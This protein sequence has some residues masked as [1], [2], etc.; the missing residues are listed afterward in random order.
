M[1]GMTLATRHLT[2]C[3]W[4]D[5]LAETYVAIELSVVVPMYNEAAN[6][7]R[8]TDELMA[9]LCAH[10]FEIILV[11]DGSTDS[12]LAEALRLR[13]VSARVHVVRHPVQCGQS[14]AVCSGV[15]AARAPWIA[16]IDGDCQNDP[17]DIP[18]LLIA[19]DAARDENVR[20]I[21]GCRVE[22][23]DSSWRRIQ[24]RVANIVRGWLLRDEAPD[25]GCGLKLFA[26]DTFLKLP[27]FDHMHR[28]LPALFMR[29]GAR[30]ISVP[31]NHR[32]RLAG[33]SKYGMLD[34]LGAGIVDLAGV[35]WLVKRA[36]P[37][38]RH[39]TA[40]AEELDRVTQACERAVTIPHGHRE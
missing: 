31:V 11:D 34:R 29:E 25:G 1:E 24:S 32:P 10:S 16:T 12:T 3:S 36:W 21:M 28:F 23:H 27:R 9:A 20:L 4:A 37:G 7:V 6:V 39:G 38:A 15:F 5:K 40:R 17:R 35:M 2:R 22:R 30:V 18:S 8:I 33:F 26:R 13:A 19:R 14:A